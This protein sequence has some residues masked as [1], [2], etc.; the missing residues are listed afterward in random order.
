MC[1]CPVESVLY[2][3]SVNSP[4]NEIFI[5]KDYKTTRQCVLAIHRDIILSDSSYHS[6]L[7][8]FR[9]TASSAARSRGPRFAV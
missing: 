3:N 2:L 5:N 4:S 7:R 9:V 8:A 1:Q 6:C